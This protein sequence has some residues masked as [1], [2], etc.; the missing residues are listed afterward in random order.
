ME[1]QHAEYDREG[2]DLLFGHKGICLFYMEAIG[3][4]ILL[5]SWTLFYV[6]G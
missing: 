1:G 6:T 3:R 5:L 2:R 4:P